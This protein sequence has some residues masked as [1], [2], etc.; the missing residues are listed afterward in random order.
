MIL[1]GRRAEKSGHKEYEQSGS[2][3]DEEREMVGCAGQELMTHL[4][5]I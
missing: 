2:G 4:P 3:G 1:I 5:W